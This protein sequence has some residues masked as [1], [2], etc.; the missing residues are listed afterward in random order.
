M[1]NEFL[2]LIRPIVKH[3]NYKS[4][5]HYMHHKTFSTY[6]H[7]L[8]VAYMSYRF[9]KKHNSKVDIPTL[10]R[11]ALLHDYY[12]YD[13]HTK[14]KKHKWH[15]YKHPKFS[16]NNALKDFKFLNDTE[17]DIILHHMFPLTLSMPK[18]KAGWIVC[19]CD[20]KA[21]LSDYLKKKRRKSRT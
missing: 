21:T 1:E 10:V 15:G 11:G 7:S 3:P 2:K 8:K 4:M 14:D 9:A 6:Y 20:K 13:W 19:W 16:Y 5:K 12:L 17:K 18:T